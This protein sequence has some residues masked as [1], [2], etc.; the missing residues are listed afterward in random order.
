MKRGTTEPFSQSTIRDSHSDIEWPYYHLPSLTAAGIIHGFMTRSSGVLLRDE[1]QREAFVE[2]LHATDFIIMDQVHGD[3]VHLV[4]D[5]QRPNRGDGLALLE[6]G[7]VGVVK[8]ADC[9]PVILYDLTIPVVAV[10]HAGWRGTVAR[11]VE[12]GVE[13][14]EKAGVHR[15]ALGALL[16]PGIGPCC[17]NVGGDVVKR[18]REAGFGEEIFAERDGSVFLDVKKANTQVLQEMGVSNIHDV[19]LCTS[20]RQDLFYSARRNGHAGRQLNFVLLK[21]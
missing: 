21:R 9:L 5:G 8:T 11:I 14:M 15:S 20:C 6:K 2:A 4:S 7:V 1:A 18:F 16:G 12:K 10:I 3:D 17:Y 19:G 13:R